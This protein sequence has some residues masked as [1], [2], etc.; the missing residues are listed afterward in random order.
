MPGSFYFVLTG[1]YSMKNMKT[2]LFPAFAVLSVSAAAIVFAG[3]YTTKPAGGTAQKG[4]QNVIVLDSQGAAFGQKT[5]DWL[6][7]WNGGGNTA[8]QK[9]KDYSDKTVFV[10]DRIEPTSR[11]F[12]LEWVK[13][14]EGPRAAATIIATTVVANVRAAL[15][16]EDGQDIETNLNRVSNQLVH[17]SFS[18]LRM[19]A[20]WWQLERNKTTGVE[21]YRAW[22]LW[23]IDTK[24]LK[25]QVAAAIATFV[26]DRNNKLSEAENAAYRQFMDDLLAG[27][28]IEFS[29]GEAEIMT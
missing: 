26:E 6:L 1:V 29:A 19:D 13:G 10:V 18:G 21:S 5:P 16:S 14:A 15:S 12:A 11:E 20:Q 4:E 25:T 27:S 24:T 17:V 8:V 2:K 23:I 9:L 3:C 22:G 28:D 7:A